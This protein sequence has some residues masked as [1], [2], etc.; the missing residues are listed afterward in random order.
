MLISMEVAYGFKLCDQELADEHII[1]VWWFA[2]VSKRK[3]ANPSDH[4]G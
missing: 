4:S 1:R 2:L 3:E